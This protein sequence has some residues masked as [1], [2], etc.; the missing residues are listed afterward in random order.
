M[1]EGSRRHDQNWASLR[2]HI[3]PWYALCRKVM[4]A[5]IP[6]AAKGKPLSFWAINVHRSENKMISVKFLRVWLQT[7]ICINA[8]FFIIIPFCT[9]I[10]TT[11]CLGQSHSAMRAVTVILLECQKCLVQTLCRTMQ[12]FT[13]SVLFFK[14]PIARLV[15]PLRVLQQYVSLL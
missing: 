15:F 14:M 9:S 5:R 1:R 8:L 6:E 3:K 2:K 12:H 11:V 4:Q 13:A 7:I 10:Y